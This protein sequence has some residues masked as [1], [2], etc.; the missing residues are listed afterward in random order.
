MYFRLVLTYFL[1]L[2]LPPSNQGYIILSGYPAVRVSRTTHC[3]F[4]VWVA[5]PAM[6]K[7]VTQ[8]MSISLTIFGACFLSVL[9]PVQ[10]R[11]REQGHCPPVIVTCRQRLLPLWLFA[12]STLRHY[13]RQENAVVWIIPELVQ[14]TLPS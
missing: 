5:H 10:I 14:H 1:V 7:A 4:G 6:M 9:Y 8:T 3:F 13:N 2:D 12:V 11:L